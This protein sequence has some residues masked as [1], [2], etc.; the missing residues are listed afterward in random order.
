VQVRTGLTR[1]MMNLATKEKY[2]KVQPVIYIPVGT[3]PDR[4]NICL[5]SVFLYDNDDDDDDDNEDDDDDDD[6]VDEVDDHNDDNKAR[7]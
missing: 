5:K 7:R 6:E 2:S 1:L 3:N 4:V